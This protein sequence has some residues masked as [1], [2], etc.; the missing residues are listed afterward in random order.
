MLRHPPKG[1][2][3][4]SFPRLAI[5]QLVRSEEMATKLLF[6]VEDVFDIGRGCVLA[7]V[8]PDGLDFRIRLK[9]RIQLRT[10]SGPA[11]ETHIA[12]IELLKPLGG[13]PCRMAIMFPRDLVKGDVPVGTE[14]WLHLPQ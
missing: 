8:I 1:T 5:P 9:D 3:F 14:V 7:P 12:S 11:V 13:G 10:P 4:R 6:K 2:D